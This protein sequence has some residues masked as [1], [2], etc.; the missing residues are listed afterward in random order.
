MLHEGFYTP[1][2]PRHRAVHIT[3]SFE[4][5]RACAQLLASGPPHPAVKGAAEDRIG[6]AKA[7]ETGRGRASNAGKGGEGSNGAGVLRF[8]S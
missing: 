4:I 8:A 5:F 2:P 1:E 7:R 3:L 6:T